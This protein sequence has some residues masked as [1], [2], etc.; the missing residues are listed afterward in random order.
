MKRPLENLELYNFSHGQ[1]E[2]FN[3]TKTSREPER[4]RSLHVGSDII[5]ENVLKSC[6]MRAK[7]KK[8]ERMER[9]NW[10][11]VQKKSTARNTA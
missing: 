8:A 10:Q 3:D 4:L 9:T 1:T 2:N 6:A 11:T 7:K 5:K